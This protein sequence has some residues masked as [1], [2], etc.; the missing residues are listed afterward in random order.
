MKIR[1]A[2]TWQ[3]CKDNNTDPYGGA[4]VSFAEQWADEMEKRMEYTG[5]TVAEVAK[6]ASRDV[7]RRDGFGITGFMYG[8]AVQMLA[9]CWEHGEALRRW[10]NLDTQLGNEGERANERGTVLNP[11]VLSVGAKDDEP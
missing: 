10:H 6:A 4:C 3:K 1:D 7:D 8:C 5:A 11:A 2:E 9:G